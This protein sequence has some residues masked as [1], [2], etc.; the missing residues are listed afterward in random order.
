MLDILAVTAHPDDLEI[1]AGGIFLKARKAGQKIG[2][3]IFTRGESGGFAEMDVR[4]NEA[5]AAAEIFK[6]DYFKHLD[7]PDAGLARCANLVETLVPLLREASPKTLITLAP[8]DYHP[9]H[10]AVS[11]TV[12]EASFVAGLKMNSNDDTRWHPRNYFH[13]CGDFTHNYRRPD[14]LVDVSDVID[15]KKRVCDSHA[16]QKVTEYAMT[17][18]KSHG[19]MA[20][21]EYAEALYLAQPARWDT[22]WL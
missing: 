14:I 20:G 12:R 21:C 9:D 6:F 19:M 8:D 3:I 4:V 5:K 13:M 11:Q 22:P 17:I 7:F 15:D 18:A 16:S 2:L 1:C 10:V